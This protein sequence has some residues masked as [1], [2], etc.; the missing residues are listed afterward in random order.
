MSC[1]ASHPTESTSSRISLIRNVLRFKS[2]AEEVPVMT[3]YH[4]TELNISQWHHARDINML[5]RSTSISRSYSISWVQKEMDHIEGLVQQVVDELMAHKAIIPGVWD[6]IDRLMH[7][8]LH[9]W[10]ATWDPHDNVLTKCAVVELGAKIISELRQIQ[11]PRLQPALDVLPLVIYDHAVDAAYQSWIMEKAANRTAF[12]DPP[13]ST[14]VDLADLGEIVILRSFDEISHALKTATTLRAPFDVLFAKIFEI[15][16]H[17][18]TFIQKKYAPNCENPTTDARSNGVVIYPLGRQEL[19]AQASVMIGWLKDASEEGHTLGQLAVRYK[20]QDYLYQEVERELTCDLVTASTVNLVLG[21]HMPVFGLAIHQHEAGAYIC[22]AK[23]AP[24][25]RWQPGRRNECAC[26]GM[27]HTV[28]EFM[29][30]GDLRKLSNYLRFV[31]FLFAH[32]EWSSAEVI[33][34][35]PSDDDDWI[36]R[37]ALSAFHTYGPWRNEDEPE[38]NILRQKSRPDDRNDDKGD[39]GAGAGSSFDGPNPDG[40]LSGGVVRG[41]SSGVL[42]DSSS[43]AICAQMSSE[44]C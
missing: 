17:A 9:K 6:K 14:S 25:P 30:F 26:T 4:R 8:L 5:K 2:W 27:H 10:E 20:H 28:A 34:Y 19:S 18:E 41:G 21:V 39:D 3:S 32:K 7:V 15:R 36:E 44:K 38:I 31:S 16:Y 1:F 11:D 29:H 33:R 43:D 40:E 13:V 37:R 24:H 12:E 23:P 35:I 22:K 42:N